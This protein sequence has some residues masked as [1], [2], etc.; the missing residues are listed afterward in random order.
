MRN[1]LKCKGVEFSLRT[2]LESNGIVSCGGKRPA[3]KS[4]WT[5]GPNHLGEHAGQRASAPLFGSRPGQAIQEQ[6]AIQPD[7]CPGGSI[8]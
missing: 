8:R 3:V 5:G 4:F 1:L 6:L 2:F 7:M